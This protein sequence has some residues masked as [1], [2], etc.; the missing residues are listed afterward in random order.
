MCGCRTA[1]RRHVCAPG[2]LCHTCC[3]MKKGMLSNPIFL[4]VGVPLLFLAVVGLVGYLSQLLVNPKHD[5]LYVTADNYYYGN[6]NANFYIENGQ[7]KAH[8]DPD[9]LPRLSNKNP[10]T[11]ADRRIRSLQSMRLNLFDVSEWRSR[12]I[13]YEDAQK[14]TYDP[15]PDSPD[16]Y[17]IERSEGTGGFFPFFFFDRDSGG[18]VMKKGLGSRPL[19]DA[20]GSYSY[21]GLGFLGW[22][23]R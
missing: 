13:S 3:I 7:L 4:I 9:S 8:E 6:A 22:V 19:P 1:V 17:S 2:K 23:I 18:F 5:F 16:G 15:A 10:E 21:R 14:L 20:V 11:D 12:P